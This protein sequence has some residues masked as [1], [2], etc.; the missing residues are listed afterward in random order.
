MT[1]AKFSSGNYAG[2]GVSLDGFFDCGCTYKRNSIVYT[3]AALVL[4]IAKWATRYM[5]ACNIKVFTDAF[6]NNGINMV[7][8]VEQSNNACVDV[9]IS[10]HLDFYKAPSGCLPLYCSAEGKKLALNI[11]KYLLG[12]MKESR[13]IMKRTDLYE[14]HATDMPACVVEVGSIC[15]DLDTIINHPRLIGKAI[16][17]G[18]CD[19]LGVDW[20]YTYYR[21][22]VI[23][24]GRYKASNSANV[25]KTIKKGKRIA[26]WKLSSGRKWG[27]SP[28][29]GWVKLEDLERV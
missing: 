6:D 21:T 20:E 18:V 11:E 16:A 2:H 22:S 3:E 23:T 17:H 19:Y 28:R 25:R 4:P 14:L 27:Y 29:Y 12:V 9:H 10:I 7:L 13:G 1:S 26:I 24:K 15:A 5:R 8:Q